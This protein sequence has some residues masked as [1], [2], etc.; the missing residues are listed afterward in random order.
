MTNISVKTATKIEF[1]IIRL[2]S[3]AVKDCI[4]DIIF[5]KF[6]GISPVIFYNDILTISSSNYST[7]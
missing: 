1:I 4:I 2:Y 3:T 5:C 7:S 6:M